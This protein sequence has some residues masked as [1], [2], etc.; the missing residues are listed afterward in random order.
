MITMAGTLS[1]A[2]E[3]Q[4]MTV[5]ME[6]ML[7]VLSVQSET[8]VSELQEWT[9]MLRLCRLMS[10]DEIFKLAADREKVRDSSHKWQG[11]LPSLYTVSLTGK[12]GELSGTETKIGYVYAEMGGEWRDRGISEIC[13]IPTTS[14]LINERNLKRFQFVSYFS[15]IHN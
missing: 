12:Q 8:M 7:Q 9:E 5:G 10:I 15:H 11:E 2:M 1:Q 13:N 4:W 6:H 3:I 14:I